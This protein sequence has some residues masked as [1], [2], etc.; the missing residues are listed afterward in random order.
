MIHE[1]LRLLRVFHDYKSGE[2]AAKLGISQSYLSEVEN[3]KKKPTLDL[4]ERYGEV[5]NIKVSTLMFFSEEL[6]NEKDTSKVYIRN[7]MLKFL[8]TIEK[9]GD[10]IGK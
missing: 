2:L 10:L 4:L 8:K 9:H 1:A 5:F 6:D 3:Q 7:S